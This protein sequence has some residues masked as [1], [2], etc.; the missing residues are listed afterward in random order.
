MSFE[1]FERAIKSTALRRVALHWNEVRGANKL[2]AWNA[3]RPAAIASELPM[4]W[5]Y[6]YDRATDTFTGRLSGDAIDQIFGR[7]IKGVPMRELYPASDYLRLFE[8]T[9]RV[10]CDPVLYRGE[11]MVF[12]HKG[13][14]G[15]G[16]RIMMPMGNDGTKGDGIFGATEYQV[17]LGEASEH[18]PEAESWF[19]L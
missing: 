8:R 3:I 16:E 9:K 19:Q 4:V 6:D 13:R 5:S 14:Y 2:P 15:L 1:Q 7:N 11:G 17:T 12:T 10:V 18:R